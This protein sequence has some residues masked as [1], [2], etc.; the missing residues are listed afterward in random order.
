MAIVRLPDASG[1]YLIDLLDALGAA[2]D[3]DAGSSHEDE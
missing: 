2:R 1:D 3:I